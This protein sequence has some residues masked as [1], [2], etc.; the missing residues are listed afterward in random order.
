MLAS[1]QSV[2]RPWSLAGGSASVNGRRRGRETVR[3]HLMLS[4][5]NVD[6][7]VLGVLVRGQDPHPDREAFF[8]KSKIIDTF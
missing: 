6:V 7:N 5:E 2:G 1:C 4:G 8:V 3:E